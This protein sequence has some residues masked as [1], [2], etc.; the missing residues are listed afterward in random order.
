MLEKKGK[1]DECGTGVVQ[2]REGIL[3]AIYTNVFIGDIY[4]CKY[5]ETFGPKT[6]EIFAMEFR[7]V[8]SA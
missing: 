3:L 7:Q 1:R 8:F 5:T 2:V 4:K 6:N